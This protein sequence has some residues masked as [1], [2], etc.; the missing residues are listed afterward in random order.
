[1]VDGGVMVGVDGMLP[2]DDCVGGVVFV[3]FV[4]LEME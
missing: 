2:C 3:E 4:D 1:M